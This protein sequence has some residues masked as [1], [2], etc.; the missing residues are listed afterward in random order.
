[1]RLR[2]LILTISVLLSFASLSFA[3]ELTAEIQ[4]HMTP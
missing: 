3:D 4:K 1:M 2:I